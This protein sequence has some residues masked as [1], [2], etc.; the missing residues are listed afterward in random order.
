[1]N[2]E[3]RI[4]RIGLLKKRHKQ[5]DD[6]IKVFETEKSPE[7]SIKRAKIEKLKVKDEITALEEYLKLSKQ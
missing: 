3:D 1:M 2:N 7:V 5:L 4:H 6:T